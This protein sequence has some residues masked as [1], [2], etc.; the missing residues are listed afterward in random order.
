MKQE[1]NNQ[2]KSFFKSKLNMEEDTLQIQMQIEKDE[3]A[4]KEWSLE[5]TQMDVD[6]GKKE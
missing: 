6:Y 4:E 3:E 1:M 5:E 2:V